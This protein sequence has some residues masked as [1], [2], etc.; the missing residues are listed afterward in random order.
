MVKIPD[1][2]PEDARQLA[3]EL[4]HGTGDGPAANRAD[5]TAH[6]ARSDDRYVHG[7]LLVTASDLPAWGA[8]RR[9]CRRFI[10]PCFV[11][12]RSSGSVE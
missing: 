5:A 10:K 7:S 12:A 6:V 1:R 11:A 3:E 4:E 9:A 8:S 2:D